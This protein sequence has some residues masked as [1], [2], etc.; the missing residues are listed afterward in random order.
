MSVTVVRAG[1]PVIVD[2]TTTSTTSTT[3]IP[4]STTTTTQPTTT[5][6]SLPRTTTTLGTAVHTVSGGGSGTLPYTGADIAAGLLLAALLI[7]VGTVLVHQARWRPRGRLGPIRRRR[8]RTD[9]EL[10]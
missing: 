5:T 9:N 8:S 10:L 6:T 3:S 1:G 7:S 4:G 2:V